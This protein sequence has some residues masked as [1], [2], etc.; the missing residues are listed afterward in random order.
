MSDPSNPPIPHISKTAE[1]SDKLYDDKTLENEKFDKTDNNMKTLILNYIEDPTK[2]D[3]LIIAFNKMYSNKNN[4][5]VNDLSDKNNKNEYLTKLDQPYNGGSFEKEVLKKYIKIE[6]SDKI[7]KILNSKTTSHERYFKF[8]RNIFDFHKWYDDTS[9]NITYNISPKKSQYLDSIDTKSEGSKEPNAFYGGDSRTNFYNGICQTIYDILINDKTKFDF[10]VMM[11]MQMYCIGKNVN[12]WLAKRYLYMCVGNEEINSDVSLSTVIDRNKD[13]IISKERYQEIFNDVVKRNNFDNTLL[14]SLYQYDMLNGITDIADPTNLSDN[15]KQFSFATYDDP[16]ILKHQQ[17]MK[18][19]FNKFK[20][21]FL[22]NDLETKYEVNKT[23]M[24]YGDEKSITKFVKSMSDDKTSF[25]INDKSKYNNFFAKNTILQTALRTPRAFSGG[26]MF[27]GGAENLFNGAN[28]YRSIYNNIKQKFQTLNVIMN[29][30]D[31]KKIDSLI[32]RTAELETKLYNILA[33]LNKFI[34]SDLAE[35]KKHVEVNYDMIAAA[36]EQYE[37]TVK[38][39]NKK[40]YVLFKDL[41][42][43]LNYSRKITE[44]MTI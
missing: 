28:L 7:Y 12:Y 23:N 34:T 6:Y 21:T 44:H 1:I 3:E 38:S 14:F 43:L 10:T 36:V 31:K 16:K 15:N 37:K 11:I 35:D 9:E 42:I 29:E 40:N 24:G 27:C 13:K 32:D 18:L 33:N 8:L 22:R 5:K 41:M 30:E 26:K 4:K 2:M 17:L 20:G 25:N 19:I 39:Y